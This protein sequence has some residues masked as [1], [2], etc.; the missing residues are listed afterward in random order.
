MRMARGGWAGEAEVKNREGN[1]GDV[2]YIT[3]Q[4]ASIEAGA[5]VSASV[6]ASYTLKNT[7]VVH[8]LAPLTYERGWAL[9]KS[10]H[11]ARMGWYF[12]LCWNPW[13][14]F[15]RLIWNAAEALGVSVPGAPRVFGW[16]L[17]V[18]PQRVPVNLT[19]T[20]AAP[21]PPSHP[22]DDTETPEL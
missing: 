10:F 11:D 2:T 13:R 20:T 22:P 14:C 3:T 15:W 4:P 21:V 7:T 1:E 12:S 5:T 9:M 17:G 6:P 8:L 18:K 16:C 19:V